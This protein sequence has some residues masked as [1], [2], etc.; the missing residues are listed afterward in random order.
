MNQLT[1]SVERALGAHVRAEDLT[2]SQIALRAILVFLVWLTIVRLQTGA[3]SAST[4]PST[5][6]S[7]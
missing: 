7:R 4:A 5:S 6:C 1:S 2:I 3:C